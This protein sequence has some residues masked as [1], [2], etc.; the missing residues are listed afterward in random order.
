MTQ[1]A[2]KKPRKG[3]NVNNIT[4]HKGR[5]TKPYLESKRRIEEFRQTMDKWK[6][7]K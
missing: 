6:G 4:H 3:Y 7:E 2:I 5:P 1:K